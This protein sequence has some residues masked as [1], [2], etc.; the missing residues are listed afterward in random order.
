M[1]KMVLIRG[2]LRGME[3]ETR[4]EVLV[5]EHSVKSGFRGPR[6]SEGFVLNAAEDLL[7]GEYT[8]AFDG[9]SLNAI[10]HHGIWLTSTAI[11]RVVA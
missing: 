4:C 6:Y 5:R 1:G 10:R 3:R 7:D 8:V 9:H 11:V 2:V